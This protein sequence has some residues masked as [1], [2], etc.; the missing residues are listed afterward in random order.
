MLEMITDRAILK[1]LCLSLALSGLTTLKIPSKGFS[2]FYCSLVNKVL[3]F[4][5]LFS[6]YD[7]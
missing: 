3:K 2:F 6:I 1:R 7:S 4:S 5:E